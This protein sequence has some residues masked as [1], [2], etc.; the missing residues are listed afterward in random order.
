MIRDRDRTPLPELAQIRI[1]GHTRSAFLVRAS[2]AAAASVGLGAVTPLTRNALAQGTSDIAVVNYALTLE[3]VEAAFY[4]QA[5][6]SVAGM[7]ADVRRL[8]VE[9]R[10]NED[11]HVEVLVGVVENLGAKPVEVPSLD[12]GGAFADEAAFLRL[13]AAF[14]DTGVEAYNGAAPLIDEVSILAAAGS[15]VQVEARHA[16]LIRLE[17]GEMPAPRAFEKASSM[18]EVL[19]TVGRYLRR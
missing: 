11:Q 17:R 6:R 18:D 13:A 16:A 4:A 5:L 9:L 10:D 1:G 12:F 2:L 15:I 14:E 19:E 3:Y 8:V 7:S